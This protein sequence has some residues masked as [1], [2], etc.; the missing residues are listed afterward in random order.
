[1]QD[2]NELV[3]RKA[4][5]VV[6]KRGAWACVATVCRVKLGGGCCT[7]IE[8]LQADV[9]MAVVS[10]DEMYQYCDMMCADPMAG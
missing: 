2:P 7:A 3:E 1:M 8:D 10:V 4:T 9:K 5:Y 6:A